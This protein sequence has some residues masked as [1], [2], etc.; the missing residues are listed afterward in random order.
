MAALM[1]SV[2]S[3]RALPS[4]EIS[5]KS[6]G[7]QKPPRV[8]R[9]LVFYLQA[10]VAPIIT[11]LEVLPANEV[12][13]KSPEHDDVIIGLDKASKEADSGE[14]EDSFFLKPKKANRQGFRTITWEASDENEDKLAFNVYLRREGENGWRLMQEKLA[15][16]V[17]S[18]DTRNF[19]D[20]TY[21]LKVEATDLP[22]NP[23]GTEK[24]I[25]KISQPLVIDNS[26][27]AVKNFMTSRSS[28]GLEVSF[29]RGCLFLYRR[30]EI[31]DQARRLAGGFPVDGL[32][33]S[34][35]ENFRF[36]VKV[37]TGSDNLLL[38]RLR[39]SFGNVGVH[40]HRF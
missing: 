26:L 2:E 6:P 5:L 40:Q 14:D 9:L 16:K 29:G 1:K 35:S 7:A 4:A 32:C 37:P 24:K 12:F 19:P 25:E 10:N 3:G 36:S 11:R 34:R 18:F 13:I 31:H 22:S 15:D 17:F 23:P 33:D 27:P 38:I 8:Q 30:S 20:G 28:D 21:W 39:D